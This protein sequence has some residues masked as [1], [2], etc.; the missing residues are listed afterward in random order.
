MAGLIPHKKE[1]EAVLALI[2]PTDDELA[3]MDPEEAAEVRADALAM[4][5]DVVKVAWEA[6]RRRKWFALVHD[7]GGNRLVFGPEVSLTALQKWALN[8]LNGGTVSV[9]TIHPTGEHEDWLEAQV[10]EWDQRRENG[11]AACGHQQWAH[12]FTNGRGKKIP[13]PK[14]VK[15]FCSATCTCTHFQLREARAA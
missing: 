8:H 1:I 11:C 14:T 13:R 4:S 9:V 6:L 3:E 7:F 10:K 12:E 15:Y 2:G 5:K